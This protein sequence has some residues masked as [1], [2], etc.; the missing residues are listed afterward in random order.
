[1]SRL[2]VLYAID[3]T[4]LEA[5]RQL[6]EE[7][8]YEYMLEEI[9]PKLL[10]TDYG[11]ELDKSWE[12]IQYCLG[13]GKWNEDNILPT[14][15]VFAGEFLVENE[16]EII[17]LKHKDEVKAIADYLETADLS[18]LIRE[19]YPQIPED[20]YMLP[21]DDDGLTYLLDW[22]AGLAEFYQHAAQENRQVI[23]TVDL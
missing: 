10:E 9:E 8:R 13:N 7:E 23:F 1:M 5:L 20:E 4:A 2:G 3:D 12:G 22:A 17:T 21:K 14:N 18:V 11:Y 19:N 15:V 16:D 6:S